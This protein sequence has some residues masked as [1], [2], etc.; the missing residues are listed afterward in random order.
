VRNLL[1]ALGLTVCVAG[2]TLWVVEKHNDTVGVYD[3]ASGKPLASIKVGTRPHE[4]AL[5]NDGSKLYVT[6]YGVNSYSQTDR[7][8]NSISVIDV[9]QRA[10]TGEID[11]GEYH[12]PH[13]IEIGR[14]GLLYVTT[15]EPA[16]VLIVDPEERRVLARMDP[17]Q[18]LP[19]MVQLSRDETK[20]YSANSGSGSVSVMNVRDHRLIRTID[21]GGVPMGFA[22]DRRGERLYVATRS[23]HQVVVL[24]TRRD[25]VIARWE[26]KGQPA[27]LRLT[28]DERHLLVSLIE[29]GEVAAVNV[30]NGKEAA[31]FTVGRNA[32]GLYT[33]AV[34]RCGYVS[35]QGDNE[36][37][38]FS[39]T[40]WKV[41]RRIPTAARPDPML[42][43]R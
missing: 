41:L 37:V 14:D 42:I 5:S 39:L 22:L 16:S 10:V 15:D 4:F 30:R 11:L 40:D 32:E 19:H 35:A 33:D 13:G 36:I 6:N 2:Q 7:G 17:G 8:A 31:R 27:R 20:A 26:V 24:D 3:L 9:A 29:S 38:E 1:L 18:K 12:R 34:S 23:G 25:V 43:L 21:V 28:P